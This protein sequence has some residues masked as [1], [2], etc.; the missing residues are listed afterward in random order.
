MIRFIKLCVLALPLVVLSLLAG[1]HA[2]AQ[3]QTPRMIFQIEGYDPRDLL[4]GQYLQFRYIWP[5]DKAASYDKIYEK[6]GRYYLPED[7]A[8]RVEGLLRE[9]TM[10]FAVE[11]TV[12][13]KAIIP[14]MLLI[15]GKPWHEIVDHLP[16]CP[17]GF[18]GM[19]CVGTAVRQPQDSTL[20]VRILPP[21]DA[22][23]PDMLRYSYD[24]SSV[25]ATLPAT[26]APLPQSGYL[27]HYGTLTPDV[28]K[29]LQ[30]LLAEGKHVFTV[31]TQFSDS[32]KSYDTGIYI[33]GKPLQEWLAEQH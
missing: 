2:I 27:N 6:N 23:T 3:A 31:E 19:G 22:F 13:D 5:D 12:T 33:D 7:K 20:R 30:T 24:W 8:K 32:G 29:R 9:G 1:Y 26:H 25:Q 15:D 11:A 17:P 14:V 10:K 21:T 4:R 16:D 18:E 28:A